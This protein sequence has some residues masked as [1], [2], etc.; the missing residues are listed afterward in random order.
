M[1]LCRV[2]SADSRSSCHMSLVK[3][4]REDAL[5][6]VNSPLR[7]GTGTDCTSS[8]S[9]GVMQKFC[10]MICREPGYLHENSPPLLRPW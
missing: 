9:G 10:H 8:L 6:A 7:V 4:L 1:P 5:S 3:V 2:T